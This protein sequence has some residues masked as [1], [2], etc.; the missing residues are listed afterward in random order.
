MSHVFPERIEST[1]DVKVV[2]PKR[3]ITWPSKF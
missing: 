3:V 2:N 1:F